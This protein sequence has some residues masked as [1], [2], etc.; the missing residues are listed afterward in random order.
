[1]M[2]T[3]LFILLTISIISAKLLPVSQLEFLVMPSD[4]TGDTISQAYD[5]GVLS[6]DSAGA[7]YLR[8]TIQKVDSGSYLYI[9]PSPY[10]LSIFYNGHPIY[11][12]G[13]ELPV[14]TIAN[15]NAEAI[16]LPHDFTLENNN[17][18]DIRMISDGARISLPEILIGNYHETYQKQFWVSLL[19]HHLIQIIVGIGFFSF[20]FLFL[21]LILVQFKDE[22]LLF[23]SVFCLGLVAT[24]SMFIMN[25][26]HF[27]QVLFFKI[28]RIGGVTMSLTLFLF[29]STITDYLKQHTY[30]L[31]VT[32]A[33][34]PYVVMILN[35]P[36][37]FSING[38]FNA[39]TNTLIFPLFIV[40]LIMLI[41]SVIR[42]HR[43]E[44]IAVLVPYLILMGA[45]FSD[46]GYMIQFQQPNFW[47]IP[48]GYLALVAG[49]TYFIL[50]NRTRQSVQYRAEAKRLEQDIQQLKCKQDDSSLVLHR[51]VS[52][53]PILSRYSETSFK[54]LMSKCEDHEGKN[55]LYNLYDLFFNFYIYSH[56]MIY[57]DKIKQGELYLWYGGFSLTNMFDNRKDAF[58]W[59]AEEKG[60]EL[61]MNIKKH[62]F[63]P[64]VWGDQQ[65][66]LIALSNLIISAVE[67]ERHV[68][69]VMIHYVAY[70][71][72]EIIIKGD[73]DE[74]N[75]N[76]NTLITT[77]SFHNEPF[78]LSIIFEE[79]RQRLD[80][81]ISVYS[82]PGHTEHTSFIIPLKLSEN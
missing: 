57:L 37:K 77:Q 36:T 1:M 56:N 26:Y 55:E 65:A 29:V 19:N 66:V 60:V 62:T 21:Y 70:T 50:Y 48:Y 11:K 8:S 31:I 4:S 76:L 63:P 3:I 25:S 33:F 32:A 10:A 44:L 72:L 53:F 67:I 81:K 17:I 52:E 5:G 59:I 28:G 34:V 35:S 24:Y 64:L 47:K 22:S 18:L 51:L 23:L 30:R 2:R 82:F 6:I 38:V 61:Q 58:I 73:E 16:Q 12:W 13:E 41:V 45:V 42:S 68:L 40:G 75:A 49:G 43:L 74:F 9:G 27:D 71:G 20:V 46:M 7:Y 54:I 14:A 39:A 78:G 69:R 15:Y 80:A 79:L